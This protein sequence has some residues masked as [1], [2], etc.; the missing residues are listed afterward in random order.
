MNF[1]FD[2]EQET[3]RDTLR[4]F[5]REHWPVAESRRLAGGCEPAVWRRLT[6]ELGVSGLAIPEELG[7]QGGSFLEL[8]IALHE[9]GRELAGG[10]LFATAL[11]ARV[12][13]DGATR[14]EQAELLPALAAGERTA[15]L[16][17]S[18]GVAPAAR[19]EA[20]GSGAE[21]SLTGEIRFAIDGAH[22]DLVIAPARAGGGEL[23]L[24]AIG[25]GAPGLSAEPIDALD[26]TRRFAHLTL[27][28][29]RARRLGGRGDVAAVLARAQSE[30]AIAASAEQL[31]G[32]ERCLEAAVAHAKQR[33]QFGRPIGSFQSLKHRLADAL[34]LLDLARSAAHWAWWV[35]ARGAPE[36]AEAAHVAKLLGVEVYERCAGDEIHVHGGMG[37]TW[38]HDAHLYY[39][40]ARALEAL[41]GDSA[42]RRAEL[43]GQLGLPA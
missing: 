43:A 15:T 18:T 4:A 22:A 42:L 10:P 11:A 16:A 6:Q 27:R 21:L 34:M 35:A 25:R 31:G 5:V 24:C 20:S 26:L 39:R 37:F 32:A 36:L 3:L 29:V 8:G 41:F 33:F 9:L 13:L 7:G 28:G 19:L 23:A 1:A 38:E 40:R 2:E 12:L 14:A 30:A 17:F